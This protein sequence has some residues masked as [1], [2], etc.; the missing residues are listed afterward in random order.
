MTQQ[1]SAE[2]YEAAA[3]ALAE[4]GQFGSAWVQLATALSLD[5]LHS[6]RLKLADAWL[7][8]YPE[9]LTSAQEHGDFFGVVALRARLHAHQNQTAEGFALLL[10]VAAF[11]PDLPYLEWLN[12]WQH[13]PIAECDLDEI[14][15]SLAGFVQALGPAQIENPGRRINAQGAL[16]LVET[17]L[18]G[19]LHHEQLMILKI[20]LLR[21]LGEKQLALEAATDHFSSAPSWRTAVTA[22][23]ACRAIGQLDQALGYYRRAIALD[24]GQVTTYLDV[25]DT[26]VERQGY[27]E[28]QQAYSEALRLDPLN[29]WARAA[30][31]IARHR[32]APTAQS[33]KE[34]RAWE[35]HETI[36]K[37]VRA[38]FASEEPSLP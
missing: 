21:R 18:A 4:D 35:N 36:G 32:V 20:T 38:L 17:L 9:A 30:A 11:R 8:E 2:D 1:S 7:K 3:I 22:A 26:C 15:P 16:D 29:I 31:S 12:Q 5:P 23:N 24:P 6:G 33:L 37:R 25:G 27:E 10:Q 28:A 34:A 14:G 19:H 13:L